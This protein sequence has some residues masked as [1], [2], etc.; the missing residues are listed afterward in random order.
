MPNEINIIISGGGTGGHLFP[1]IAIS[2]QLLKSNPK[3]NVHFVGSIYGIEK[4]TLPRNKLNYTLLPISGFQ[5]QI[6]LKS[7]YKNFM[8]PYRLIKSKLLIKN[9]FKELKPKLVIGT[10][11]YAS[12]LPLMEGIQRG[13]PLIIQE[14]NAFP[15][16]TTRWFSRKAD[17]V[18]IAFKEAQNHIDKKCILTGNPVRSNIDKG[19]R[20]QGL[21]SF[22]FKNNIKTVLIFGGSQGSLFLNKII[23]KII[24]SLCIH[25]I[26][27]LWQTGQNHYQE[28]KKFE[29]KIVKVLPFIDNMANA[30]AVSD[31]VIS[32]SGAI[33][34]SE[35]AH[36]GKPSILFPLKN[37][38]GN[39]QLK[40]AKSLSKVGA[41][42]VIE[43]DTVNEEKLK[44]LIK[45]LIKSESKL[46]KMS[47]NSI[48][49]RYPNAASHI[50]NS[51]LE[52][53]KNV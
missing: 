4:K 30:Y 25:E 5:R 47:A 12:A 44:N 35:I 3:F 53:L 49:L 48:R 24:E 41:A 40:N 20:E 33:T 13:I 8:L 2:D 15:G 23:S 1:A 18:F 9:L 32:R 42:L 28:F 27:F 46:K 26:Q 17:K 19:N 51:A 39:H 31:L 36:C 29:N 43:E 50:S 16:I 14:Q 22:S 11:G 10:G 7:I 21:K 34:C 37:S 38:A 52:L 45:N 6:N